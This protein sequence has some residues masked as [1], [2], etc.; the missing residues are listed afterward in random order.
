[1]EDMSTVESK[2]AF[3]ILAAVLLSILLASC[4]SDDPLQPGR[5]DASK[6]VQQFVESQGVSD[7]VGVYR[8]AQYKEFE[9]FRIEFGEEMDCP[10]GC[11]YWDATGVRVGEKVGWLAVARQ[12]VFKP[13]STTFFD[14]SPADSVMFEESLWTDLEGDLENRSYLWSDMLPAIAIASDVPSSVLMRLA[15]RL[16]DKVLVRVANSLIDN[17]AVRNDRDILMVLAELP[18][19][20]NG[21]YTRVRTIARRLLAGVRQ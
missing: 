16:Y 18:D 15:E 13:D 5:V 6:A 1:M 3:Q 21:A 4:G 11:F 2:R 14:V 8:L 12:D 10:S 20:G 19:L 7:L 17:P 9:A